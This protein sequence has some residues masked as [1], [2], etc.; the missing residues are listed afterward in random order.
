MYAQ[1][2]VR[3]YECVHG[4]RKNMP[5]SQN[6]RC[7]MNF[8]FTMR[9]ESLCACACFVV[10]KFLLYINVNNRSGLLCEQADVN[11]DFHC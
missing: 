3:F 11:K 8:Y 7:S 10:K 1:F 4:I 6:N 2:E 9:W 5:I